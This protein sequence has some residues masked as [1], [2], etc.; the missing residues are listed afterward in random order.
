MVSHP[1]LSSDPLIGS[2]RESGVIVLA[3]HPP[4][5]HPRRVFGCPESERKGEKARENRKQRES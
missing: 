2:D 4:S 1:G 3:A 5:C